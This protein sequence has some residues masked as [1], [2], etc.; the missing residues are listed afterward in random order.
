MTRQQALRTR[1]QS[2][3]ARE[4]EI[5]GAAQAAMDHTAGLVEVKSYDYAR[6]ERYTDFAAFCATLIAVDPMRAAEIT[7]HA[8]ELERVF[9]EQSERDGAFWTLSQPMSLRVFRPV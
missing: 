3:S 7:A 9:E 6:T 5:R 1:G 4:T 2:M 8:G